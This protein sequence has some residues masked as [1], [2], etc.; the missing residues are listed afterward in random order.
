[1]EAIVACEQFVAAIA[2]QRDLHMPGGE[3]GNDERGDCGR[4]AEGFI[5]VP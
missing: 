1:L 5:E 3:F 4:I 2:A